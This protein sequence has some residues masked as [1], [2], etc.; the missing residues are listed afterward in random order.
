MLYKQ[1]SKGIPLSVDQN[2]WLHDT[3]EEPNKQELGDDGHG[4]GDGVVSMRLIA[5]QWGRYSSGGKMDV[6]G[7][8]W[9]VVV[10]Q[11]R[12]CVGGEGGSAWRRW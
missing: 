2:E 9:L 4:V 6:T 7:W 5:C 10:W 12:R 3:D 1:E 11:W 8:L